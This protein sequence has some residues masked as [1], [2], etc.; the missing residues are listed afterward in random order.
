MQIDRLEPRPGAGPNGRRQTQGALGKGG[1][2][3]AHGC[4]ISR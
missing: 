3:V 4:T 1:Q 2:E